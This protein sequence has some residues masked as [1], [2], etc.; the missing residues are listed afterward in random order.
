MSG[1]KILKVAVVA[2]LGAL[3]VQSAAFGRTIGAHGGSSMKGGAVPTEDYATHITKVEYSQRTFSGKLESDFTNSEDGSEADDNTCVA[4]R[5][6]K[7]FRVAQ[8]EDVLINFNKSNGNGRFEISGKKQAGKKYYFTVA[9]T[10]PFFYFTYYN[11]LT[12]EFL[13]IYARCL[14]ANRDF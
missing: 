7:L 12:E 9:D 11:P 3:M 8:G 6:V 1:R 4:Q 13:D 2:A 14:G 10:E 5:K